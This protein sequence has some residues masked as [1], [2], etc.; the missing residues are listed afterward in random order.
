MRA[1]SLAPVALPP[2]SGHSWVNA[3]N[4]SELICVERVAVEFVPGPVLSTPTE[5]EPRQTVCLLVLWAQE[6]RQE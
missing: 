3:K 1:G 6:M 4:P 5:G 2:S